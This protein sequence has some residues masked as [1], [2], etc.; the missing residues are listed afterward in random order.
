MREGVTP[1]ATRRQ[2][3]SKL[4]GAREREHKEVFY[5]LWSPLFSTIKGAFCPFFFTLTGGKIGKGGNL[6]DQEGRA[7]KV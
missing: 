4:T 2:F 3:V 6:G 1:A 7:G 5:G